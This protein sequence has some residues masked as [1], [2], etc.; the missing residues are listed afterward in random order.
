MLDKE[1]IEKKIINAKEGGEMHQHASLTPE[2]SKAVYLKKMDEAVQGSSQHLSDMSIHDGDGNIVASSSYDGD[3]KSAVQVG[4]LSASDGGVKQEPYD[5]VD[6]PTVTAIHD[7]PSEDSA[8]TRSGESLGR[9]L[10]R[11]AVDPFATVGDIAGVA[12]DW[13]TGSGD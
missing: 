11:H 8:S 3:R 7:A 5:D 13:I 9:Y 2:E 6:G 10:V 1:I 12:Y 4:Q